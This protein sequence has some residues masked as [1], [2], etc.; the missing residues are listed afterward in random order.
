M[1]TFFFRRSVEKAFQLDE[2]PRD[3]TL[4]HSK[5]II[6]N[7]PYITS[8]VDD[9]MYIVDQM[10]EKSLA[11]SQRAVIS[12]VIPTI[13]RVLGSDFIGMVQRKMRDECYPKA[14]VHG[15]L[16]PEQ[17][18]IAFLVLINNLDVAT[19]YI[20]RI[21]RS[22]VETTLLAQDSNHNESTHSSS[23]T[24]L[25]PFHRDAL[26]VS[27]TLKSLQNSF[28]SKAIELIGD[29]ILVV[30]KNLVKPRLRPI[31]TE[32][33]RDINYQ[34]TQ[35]ELENVKAVAE[36]EGRNDDQ[37]GA[38]VIERFQ[39][40]WDLLTSPVLRIFTE[41]NYE[42]L[43]A[44]MTS[45]LSEVLEKRIW[46]YYGRLD[47]LGAVRLERDIGSVIGTVVRG[48]KY[49]LRESFARCTQI[50][51]VMNMEEDEWE[52]VHEAPNANSD[53]GIAWQI[54]A[55]ERVRARAMVRSRGL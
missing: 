15:G 41:R 51:M 53:D 47:D 29:G 50:C 10:V 54:D 11:T 23:L 38:A 6:T 22:R 2:Q 4:D 24:T 9:V 40:G 27:S 14:V 13:G 25:F 39:W 31:L 20:Q 1:A 5:P 17:T 21:V 52:E 48:G 42:K 7:P 35:V 33:F 18:T 26:V 16:P 37:S 44:L 12:S 55:D 32:A 19:N 28:D 30:F 34:L 3:L 43:L 36:A 45:Y 46:S 49:G 8:A